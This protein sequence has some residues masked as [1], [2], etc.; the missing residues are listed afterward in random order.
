LVPVFIGK[1]LGLETMGFINWASMLVSYPFVAVSFM[2]RTS[3][4]ALSRV[5]HDRETFQRVVIKL[6]RV[7]NIVV[8]AGLALIIG[9]T[10]GIIHFIFTDKWM[11]AEPLIYYFSFNIALYASG[12]L[13]SSAYNA[14][15]K[16]H[17]PFLQS[18]WTFLFHWIVGVLLVRRF[19]M[20]GFGYMV[21]LCALSHVVL[22]YVFYRVSGV[23]LWST[24][25]G[26]ATA[27]MVAALA[28]H[29]LSANMDSSVVNFATQLAATGAVY[30]SLIWFFYQKDLSVNLMEVSQVLFAKRTKA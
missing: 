13:V 9:N 8:F 19:G 12:N 17:I 10:R 30:A 15:G 20:V 1:T 16:S 23:N 27:M 18:G 3:F 14:L 24:F 25:R 7:I 6:S 11:P 22:Y 29:V 2:E 4:A 28:G 21:A 26:A 5:Q